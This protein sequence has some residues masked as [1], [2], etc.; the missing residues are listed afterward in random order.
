MYI[1]HLLNFLPWYWGT[2]TR[3][4]K[5]FK[6]YMYIIGELYAMKLAAIS[7]KKLIYIHTNNQDWYF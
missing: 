2:P 6:V 4:H 7:R 3:T 1:R 5:F